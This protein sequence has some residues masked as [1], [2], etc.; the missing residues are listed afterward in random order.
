MDSGDQTTKIL[1][2]VVVLSLLLLFFYLNIVKNNV[3]TLESKPHKTIIK[4]TIIR[5]VD[6]SKHDEKSEKPKESDSKDAKKDE[7]PK[8]S[9]SKDAKKD[10]KP[11]ESDSKDAKKDEKPKESD[12]KDAKKDEPTTS[13][14]KKIEKYESLSGSSNT[15]APYT[16]NMMNY[17]DYL[18]FSKRKSGSS[19]ATYKSSNVAPE[20]LNAPRNNKIEG[21]K[22]SGSSNTWA[23]YTE[24]MGNN[25][26]DYEFGVPDPFNKFRYNIKKCKCGSQIC[27]CRLNKGCCGN[28][29]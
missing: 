3:L 4:K 2:V 24:N 14:D 11:K 7:K 25:W 22:S 13:P 10:E 1:V 8:E 15:W 18:S 9:D 29:Y 6:S 27:K 5:T 17:F 23:P 21:Y 28:K 19:E 12:S 20:S 26:A 16:E